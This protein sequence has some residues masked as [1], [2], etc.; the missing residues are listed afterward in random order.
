M[1]R[2]SSSS[3]R[4]RSSESDDHTSHTSLTSFDGFVLGKGKGKERAVGREY[5]AVGEEEIRG[6]RYPLS[7]S[8]TSTNAYDQYDQPSSSRRGSA[9][10]AYSVSS[11]H[12]PKLRHRLS[13]ITQLSVAAGNVRKRRLL[14]FI[15]AL[16]IPVLGLLLANE[17]RISNHRTQL[18]ALAP[19][20]DRT[21]EWEAMDMGIRSQSLAK[22][23]KG[24]EKKRRKE[25]GRRTG[26]FLPIMPTPDNY[27]SEDALYA[28]VE[29]HWPEWWGSSD[30]AG[31]SPFDH[32]P[33]IS[34]GEKKRLLF[35]TSKSCPSCR[36]D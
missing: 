24:Y 9:Q 10:S 8:S 27:Y 16:S 35:L 34:K 21:H 13:S 20:E 30:I 3:S 22:L 14:H 28:E 31:P 17:I 6:R 5:A 25:L 33:V 26:P 7:G 15:L 19:N 11:S 36:C 1:S 32:T 23:R 29:D 18:H 4:R 12:E 2:E